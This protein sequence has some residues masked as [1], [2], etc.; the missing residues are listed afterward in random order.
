MVFFLQF[1][2][3]KPIFT[4][5]ATTSTRKRTQCERI[6][7][8]YIV[9]QILCPVGFRFI[10]LARLVFPGLPSPPSPSNPSLKPYLPPLQPG[11]HGAAAA[12]PP[13]PRLRPLQG[14]P[15]GPPGTQPILLQP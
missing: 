4:I 11:R 10:V 6:V 5:F 1:T 15:S 3:L 2:I 14:P 9:H 13:S 7:V 12:S 8:F